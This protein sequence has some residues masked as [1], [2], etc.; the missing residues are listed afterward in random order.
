MD[1][2]ELEGMLYDLGKMELLI[3]EKLV[4]ITMEKIKN[5]SLNIS[6]ILGISMVFNFIIYLAI[7]ITIC[8]LEIN[9]IYKI[10]VQF[11]LSSLYNIPLLV[12]LKQKN[13]K[14]ILKGLCFI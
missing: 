8:T 6:I 13:I 7:V 5:D 3:P 10:I 11:S 1:N 2:K 4:N 9:L 12:I 14:N